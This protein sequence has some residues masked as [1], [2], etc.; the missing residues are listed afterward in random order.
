MIYLFEFY[1]S[2]I[3]GGLTYLDRT[4]LIIHSYLWHVKENSLNIDF[5]RNAENVHRLHM[6]NIKTT[7]L[8]AN[9]STSSYSM[10]NF[11]L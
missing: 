2:L 5:P 4:I 6:H 11:I 8:P 1:V 7:S 10:D 3:P 9:N